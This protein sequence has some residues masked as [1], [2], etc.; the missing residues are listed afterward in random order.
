[1]IATAVS[2]VP[3]NQLVGDP[4]RVKQIMLNLLSNS[5]KFTSEGSVEVSWQVEEHDQTHSLVSIH[6]K[7]TVRPS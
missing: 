7:D 5:V 3:T 6:V 1:V 4:F 2:T